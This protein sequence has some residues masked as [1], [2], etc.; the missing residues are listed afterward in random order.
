MAN[1]KKS[2]VLIQEHLDEQESIQASVFGAY[3]VKIMGSDSVRTG[4]FVATESRL[5]F[6]AKK[7]FGYDF[8]SFP[9]KNISSIEKSKGMMGHTITIFASGNKAKMKWINTGDII[10]FT[11]F[12]NSRIGNQT[13]EESKIDINNGDDIPT[14]IEKL[15]N[16]KDKGILTEVE[17]TNKKDELLSKM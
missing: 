10:K 5:V 9:Y 11:Q 4:I 1:Y 8:E 7:L 16:L 17:F 13:L 15:S 3:E 14:Q 2:L 6:Y 12:I